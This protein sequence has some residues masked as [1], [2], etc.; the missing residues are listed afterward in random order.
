MFIFL[1]VILILAVIVVVLSYNG[2]VA[3][4]DKDGIPDAVE[5]AF[6]DLK[7]EIKKKIKKSKE[8]WDSQNPVNVVTPHILRI[9]W[10]NTFE[11]IRWNFLDSTLPADL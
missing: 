4:S 10:W 7:D 5:D 6:D 11:Q 8:S 2:I 3:D 9:V 1:S